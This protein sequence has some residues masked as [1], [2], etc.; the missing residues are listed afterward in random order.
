MYPV[1]ILNAHILITATAIEKFTSPVARKPAG[2]INEVDHIKGVTIRLLS[3]T[4][5]NI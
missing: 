3:N 4:T 5:L 1:T 2:M